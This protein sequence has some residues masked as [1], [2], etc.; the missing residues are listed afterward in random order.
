[1]KKS[2]LS[3]LAFVMLVVPLLRVASAEGS[4]EGNPANTNQDQALFEQHCLS[5]HAP[6]G[7]GRHHG[8]GSD[9]TTPRR[10]APPMAMVKKHYLGAYPERDAFVAA[11]SA[12]V[13]EPRSEQARLGHALE[14]FGLMPAQNLN[15]DTRVRIAGYIYDSVPAGKC[16]KGG[17]K[18]GSKCD[19]EGQ[20]Q[21]SKGKQACH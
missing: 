6:K 1:M 15:A 12:W 8:Q 3:H 11:V 9:S 10:L 4:N 5:C 2:P 20:G 16:K 19:G 21:G 18:H 7:E 17:G 13:A 14:T